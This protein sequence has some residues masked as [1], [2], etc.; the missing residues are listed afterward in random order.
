VA[1]WTVTRRAVS[2]TGILAL[3]LLASGC[4]SIDP[5]NNFVVANATFD[6][7]YFYCHV[8]PQYLT[9]YSCGP[10]GASDNNSCHYSPAVTGM[11]LVAHPAINCGGGDH[12]LDATQIT[13]VA[14]DDY[15][16]VEIEMSVDYMNAPLLVRPLGNNHPRPIFTTN[17]D[18]VPIQILSTWANTQ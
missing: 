5:G 13:Q 6:P 11:A 9:A 14:Q 1:A 7:D 2:T 16:A 17:N 15:A 12:P 8:E 4:D 3:V 18:Q 10:G